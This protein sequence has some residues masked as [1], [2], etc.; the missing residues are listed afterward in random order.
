MKSLK[1]IIGGFVVHQNVKTIGW[2]F[3]CVIFVCKIIVLLCFAWSFFN[4]MHWKYWF[5]IDFKR[6]ILQS[7]DLWMHCAFNRV[8]FLKFWQNVCFWLIIHC[9]FVLL[10]S[11]K[12]HFIWEL[13]KLWQTFFDHLNFIGINWSPTAVCS[14]SWDVL[15]SAKTEIEALWKGCWILTND[16]SAKRSVHKLNFVKEDVH[17]LRQNIFFG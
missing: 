12:T 14:W 2:L 13:I 3:I 6:E 7:I 8:C 4:Y 16:K 5:W 17:K 9:L 1:Q 15:N 10:C 11:I